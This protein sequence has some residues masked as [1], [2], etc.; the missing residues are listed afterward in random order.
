[1]TGR[2]IEGLEAAFQTIDIVEKY[3]APAHENHLKVL[4][5][6]AL[7]YSTLGKSEEA[8]KVYE[9][10]IQLNKESGRDVNLFDVY[11]NIS[12]TYTG[13][14]D[15]ITALKY[16]ELAQANLANSGV[17]HPFYQLEIYLRHASLAIDVMDMDK[18]AKYV[19][20]MKDWIRQKFEP[21]DYRLRNAYALFH[22]YH[23]ELEEYDPAMLNLE[24][25]IAIQ[26]MY[27]GR[28][29]LEWAHSLGLERR[30]V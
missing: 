25:Y 11:L 21:T 23:R 28:S 20:L 26:E 3:Y 15:Y 4:N 14:W 6:L 19:D 17:L 24:K 18:A 8:I 1:M 10:V 5:T 29:S 2:H 9:R 22:V 7:K 27:V 13:K 16:L 12:A 30:V